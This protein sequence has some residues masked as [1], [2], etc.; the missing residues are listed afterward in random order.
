MK[1]LYTLLI[2][3]LPFVGISQNK[4]SLFGID[5]SNTTI[6]TRDSSKTIG[7]SLDNESLSYII[8]NKP[9]SF[10]VTLPLFGEDVDLLLK[11]NNTFFKNIIIESSGENG[12]E[13]LNI[14]P[15]IISYEIQ[16]E[17]LSI[18][19]LN[20]YNG[21]I[22]S[23]FN[24]KNTQYEIS[25]YN[26]QYLLFEVNNSINN[27][28]FSCAVESQSNNIGYSPV[29]SDNSVLNSIGC[30]EFA[31]DIDYFT[32]Q[33]FSSDLEATNWALAIFA[34]VAQLYQAQSNFS[35]VVD[36]L[37][38]WNITDPYAAYVQ[39]AGGMLDSFRDHW[40]ANFTDIPRDLTHLLTKRS[41]TG[42][43]GIA[44]VNVLCNTDYRYG[45]SSNLTDDTTYTFP[46]PT[47]T[48]NLNVCAHEIGHNI[49]SNHTHDCN[50]TADASLGFS[51]G[52]IDNCGVLSGS[53]SDCNPPAPYP[54]D[55]IG[56]IM[57]YCHVG[58]SGI[59]LEFNDVVLSQGLVPFLESASCL[60]E[61]GGCTDPLA[62]NYDPNA[63]ID[64][65][66]CDF[67]FVYGCDD[68]TACNYVD[69]AEVNDGSCIYAMEGFDCDSLCL[70]QNEETYVLTLFDSYGDGWYGETGQHTL[71]INGISYG[72][73]F[74]N[75]STA[76]TGLIETKYYLCID[77]D[78]CNEVS[79]INGGSWED[80]C[81]FTIS[82]SSDVIL[83]NGDYNTSNETFG[84]ACGNSALTYVPDDNFEQALIDFGYDDVSDDY[85]LTENISGLTYIDL[86]TKDIADLT[87]IEDF[88]SLTNLCCAENQL[89]T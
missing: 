6:A 60:H 82:N 56:T 64:D 27:S 39:N 9:E 77:E 37:N 80:E 59:S 32:R 58:G 67:D 44:F 73:E 25:E 47:Y 24:I 7:L 42:T 22:S 45:F 33:T 40:N 26:N 14:S 75:G 50:W 70:G 19:V 4:F 81:S 10:I 21:T 17:N 11:I 63:E 8:N 3:I 89:T 52:G 69:T 30:I 13:N 85:V 53:G 43:G 76:N 2:L 87:G 72:A 74:T 5:E 65:G 54:T 36:Y 35:V 78:I 84:D 86:C 38:I 55:G 12:R 61:C 20:F 71:L 79:F 83:I 34:G 18:G 57:S 46:N 41:N 15:T 16:F 62:M 23:T 1:A 49:G 28:G 68:P 48:W 29:D 51:G 31:I 66:S 88:V